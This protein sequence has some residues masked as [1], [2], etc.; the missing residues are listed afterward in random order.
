M[1][2]QC[3]GEISLAYISSVFRHVWMSI[4]ILGILILDA[5]S[6]MDKC[7]GFDLNLRC[8]FLA[9]WIISHIEPKTSEQFLMTP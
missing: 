1:F 7:S 4:H 5:P 6:K 8:P 2:L 3:A 9:E